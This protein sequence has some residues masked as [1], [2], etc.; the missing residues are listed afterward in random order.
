M[1][2]IWPSFISALMTSAA[3]TDSFRA[4][5]ATVIVSGIVTSRMI[6]LAAPWAAPS[7]LSSS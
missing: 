5:S 3:F 6:G 1:V 7:P 4:S 2:T